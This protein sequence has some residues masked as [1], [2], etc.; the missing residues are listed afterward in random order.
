MQTGNSHGIV[1]LHLLYLHLIFKEIYLMVNNRLT[2]SETTKS[3]Q[4]RVKV[5]RC[6]DGA[7]YI[8]D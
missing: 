6:V 7:S 5:P 1:G 4:K 8:I 3:D 2:K